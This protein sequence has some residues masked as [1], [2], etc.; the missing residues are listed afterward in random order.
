M[1][2]RRL[3]EVLCGS[4]GDSLERVADRIKDAL[5]DWEL[6]WDTER[7]AA[8]PDDLLPMSPADFVAELRGRVEEVLWHLAAVIND[9]PACQLDT[10]GRQRVAELLGVLVQE[11]LERGV[12]LRLEATEAGPPLLP[13]PEGAWAS[14]YRRMHSGDQESDDPQP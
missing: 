14:R 6:P 4:G 12:Q 13:L 1:L 2:S 3:L 5:L 10:V 8:L 11:A 9:A 7:R